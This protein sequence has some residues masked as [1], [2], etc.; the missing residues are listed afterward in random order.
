MLLAGSGPDEEAV[1]D[2]LRQLEFGLPEPALGLLDLPVR[3]S[4]GQALA[5]YAAGLSTPSHVAAAGPESLALLVGAA[6]AEDLVGAARV[7]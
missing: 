1:A 4:R 5:L 3:L 7:A 2:L 6:A